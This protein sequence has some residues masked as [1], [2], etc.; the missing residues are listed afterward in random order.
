MLKKPCV[1]TLMRSQH[2]KGSKTLLKSPQQCFC[3][4]LWSLWKKNCSKNAVLEVSEILWLFFNILTPDEKYSLS[5][6]ASVKRN[7]FKCNYLEIEKYFLNFCL[8]FQNLH[9]FSVL[10]KKRWTSEVIGFWK[11]TLQK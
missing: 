7:T 5:V 3:Q 6:K 9:K 2:V 1:G 8:N 11:Y 4:I 10:W